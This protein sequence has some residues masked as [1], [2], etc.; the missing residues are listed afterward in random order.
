MKRIRARVKY[1]GKKFWGWQVQPQ[2]PTVQG[3]IQ[4]GLHQITG[5]NIVITA[6]GRT[7]R[8]VHAL[9]QVIHFDIP[10]HYTL[11][12]LR[13]SINSVID[14]DIFLSSLEQVHPQFHSV[15]DAVERH[16]LYLLNSGNYSPP[17]I[18]DSVRKVFPQKRF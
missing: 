15:R 11:S 1:S 5:L 9:G 6:S 18:M 14:P 3:E 7:D 13:Y 16:Y 8:G 10:V 4:R 2:F 12:D 17:C